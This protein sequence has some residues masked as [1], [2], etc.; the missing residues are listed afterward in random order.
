MAHEVR[1]TDGLTRDSFR[2]AKKVW[3]DEQRYEIP[4]GEP[5]SWPHLFDT[6]EEIQVIS[7]LRGWGEWTH[8]L[9][10]YRNGMWRTY[11]AK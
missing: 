4:S 5:L 8:S 3:R 11:F 6:S 9:R 7:P 2:L 10:V 1:E